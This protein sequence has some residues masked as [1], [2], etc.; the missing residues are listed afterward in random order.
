MDSVHFWADFPRGRD[1]QQERETRIVAELRA[2]LAQRAQEG[3]EIDTLR[4]LG[5][6]KLW[7]ED[8]ERLR[9]VVPCLESDGKLQS[10]SR[11]SSTHTFDGREVIF[12]DDYVEA[13]WSDEEDEEEEYE[14]SDVE[15]G[16]DGY[17]Y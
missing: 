13:G 6:R 12:I 17:F 16:A 15:Y 1:M 11:D 9:A 7:K 3:A 5:A 14:G 4:I 2:C 8:L 10:S